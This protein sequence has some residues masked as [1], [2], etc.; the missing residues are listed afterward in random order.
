MSLARRSA[1]SMSLARNSKAPAAT[2]QRGKR[3]SQALAA[4]AP[5]SRA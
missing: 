2:S 5:S 1:I 3:L 4:I